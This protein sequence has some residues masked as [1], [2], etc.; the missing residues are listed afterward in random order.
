MITGTATQGRFGN[1]QG[2][3]FS[4]AYIVEYWRPNLGKWQKYRNA[5]GHEVYLYTPKKKFLQAIL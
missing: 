2:V 1:G 5:S 3:E 4:E